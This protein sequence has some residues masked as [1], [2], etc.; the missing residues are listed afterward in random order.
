MKTPQ[1]QPHLHLQLRLGALLGVL[2]FLASPLEAVDFGLLFKQSAGLDD[3][4]SGDMHLAKWSGGFIPWFSSML[5]DN[6]DLYISAALTPQVDN[7]DFAVIPELLRTEV[8]LRSGRGTG[9]RFGRGTYVDPLGLVAA[10]L[11]DGAQIVQDVGEGVLSVGGWYTGLQYK[12][13]ANITV[14]PRDQADFNRG[15]DSD[16]V[17]TYFSARRIVTA[18][19]WEHPAVGGLARVKLA[20]LGQF[21]LNGED[22]RYHSEYF[23]GKV[24]LPYQNRLVFEAGGA[25]EL[26][27]TPDDEAKLGLAAELGLA[28]MPPTALRDRFSLTGRYGS[29][30]AEDTPLGFFM[31]LTTVT[32]GEVLEAKLSGLTHL[33]AAYT[34]RLHETFSA[35]LSASYFLKSSK[36]TPVE[37]TGV[38]I[39]E[40]KYALGGEAYMNLV[41]NPVSDLYLTFG[42]G[43]FLPQLGDVAPKKAA[44]WK[45]EM[46]LTLAVF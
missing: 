27:Q 9:F 7:L 25:L 4:F 6:G 12:K 15:Y 37:W 11:F 28:W 38:E 24:T 36:L 17:A 21:D 23:A 29:G 13:T 5:V 20:A 22:D 30:K 44:L 16:D 39:H 19:D 32:Q 42:S 40:D 3:A 8:T 14:S 31:P 35:Q 26:L 1:S 34:A 18:V 43:V 2:L 45:F 41:A 10:G 46:G 33:R